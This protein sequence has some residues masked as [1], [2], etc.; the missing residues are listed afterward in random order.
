MRK[1]MTLLL[2]IG[3]VSCKL[4]HK[5]P[6]NFDYGQA[7]NGVYTNSFFDL[8][9]VYGKDWKVQN[10]ESVE[11]LTEQGE[12]L[13]A[14]DNER[15]KQQIKISKISTAYLFTAFKYEMGSTVSFNPSIMI[16]AEN[17]RNKVLGGTS[18]TYL[19]KI[20]KGLEQSQI[21]YSFKEKLKTRAI[22]DLEFEMLEAKVEVPAAQITQEYY[23]TVKNGFY[24][25]FIVSYSDQEQKK[26]LYQ[27]LKK[28]KLND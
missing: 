17:I 12:E 25:N 18:K 3:I 2:F 4:E 7:E 19:A 11:R 13:I 16:I 23:T 8:K 28:I 1:V 27:V 20:K 10:K 24:L 14:G 22:G 21:P 6:E 9:V 5:I 26:E 15:L